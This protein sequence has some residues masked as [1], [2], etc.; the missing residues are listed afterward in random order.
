[1]S[2]LTIIVLSML[3]CSH[4]TTA[5]PDFFGE[6]QN[7]LQAEGFGNGEIKEFNLV[8]KCYDEETKSTYK[9]D[10]IWYPVG[11]CE[12]RTCSRQ[13]NSKTPTIKTMEC[14][15]CTSCKLPN[16]TCQP[17]RS[18][19]NYPKCCSQCLTK[20]TVLLKTEPKK[21]YQNI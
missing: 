17:F 9:V 5:A 20:S 11:K 3:C 21:K 10:S 6:E 16:Q 4:L 13:K 7:V 14:E 1:M 8:T 19:K 2:K 15:P 18:D 12:K